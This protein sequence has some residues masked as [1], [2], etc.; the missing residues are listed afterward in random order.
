M[1]DKIQE[2]FEEFLTFAANSPLSS[3]IFWQLC[4]FLSDHRESVKHF[5]GYRLSQRNG[6]PLEEKF[7]LQLRIC[8]TFH[9]SFSSSGKL[10]LCDSK[11]LVKCFTNSE[12]SPEKP[13]ICQN[14]TDERGELVANVRN[15]SNFSWIFFRL[16]S[17]LMDFWRKKIILFAVF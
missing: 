7:F 2:K 13:Q 1:F 4:G 3:V 10:F 5:T 11:F 15:S 17:T 12:W 16:S 14:M 9:K 6:L 8:E